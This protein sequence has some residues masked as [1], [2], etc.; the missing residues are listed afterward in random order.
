MIRYMETDL[1]CVVVIAT[2][3]L[4]SDR[5]QRYANEAVPA[6]WALDSSLL[7]TIVVGFASKHGLRATG[8]LPW[9]INGR[10][11]DTSMIFAPGLQLYDKTGDPYDGGSSFG[12]SLAFLH[13]VISFQFQD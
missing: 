9:N 12:E 11:K 8:S 13:S 4:E 7:D 3:N 6:R 1:Q 10:A 5:P 2:G